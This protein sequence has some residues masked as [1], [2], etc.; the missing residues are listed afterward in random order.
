MQGAHVKDMLHSRDISEQQASSSAQTR[1]RVL[2]GSLYQ[3]LEERKNVRSRDEL[4]SLA[5]S[6][7]MDE[8]VLERLAQTIN[9]PSIAE[10]TRRMV[11]NDAGEERMTVM[12]RQVY[13]SA[14]LR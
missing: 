1:N 3:L 7:G 14:S 12:V 13:I 2:A 9:S 6:Y 10:E 11:T 8:T 5:N 4:T